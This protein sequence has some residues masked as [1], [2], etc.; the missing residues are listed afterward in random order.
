MGTGPATIVR[1]DGY[2]VITESQPDTYDIE[3]Y[4]ELDFQ[5][6]G[7]DPGTWERF[8]PFSGCSWFTYVAT[9]WTMCFQLP[10]A[11]VAAEAGM[12]RGAG[13]KNCVW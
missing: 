4:K 3:M 1:D 11:D 12:S 13:A 5:N 2:L 10:E 6:V 7:A 8:L 9:Q